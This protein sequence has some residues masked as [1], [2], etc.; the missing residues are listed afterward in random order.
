MNTIVCQ[1]AV[2]PPAPI[3]EPAAPVR[4]PA[5]VVFPGVLNPN[6]AAREAAERDAFRVCQA[7]S[8]EPAAWVVEGRRC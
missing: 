8:V 6:A 3:A 4:L 2:P 5:I 1:G 7:M